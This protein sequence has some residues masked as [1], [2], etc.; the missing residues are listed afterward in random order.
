MTKRIR[1][2]LALN[3]EDSK[4]AEFDVLPDEDPILVAQTMVTSLFRLRDAGRSRY[5]CGWAA[6]FPLGFAD[7]DFFCVGSF[8]TLD[9]AGIGPSRRPLIAWVPAYLK[10]H[11][12]LVARGSPTRANP[13]PLAPG[14][15]IRSVE[16]CPPW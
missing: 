14:E 6:G 10:P 2:T 16:H 4:E 1:I 11:R 13:R 15:R 9:S 12:T 7:L 5:A 8:F 3:D